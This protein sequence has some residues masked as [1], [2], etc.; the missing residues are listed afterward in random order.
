MT[1][2]LFQSGTNR[3][4]SL[5]ELQAVFGS[6]L[7][8]LSPDFACLPVGESA[9]PALASRYQA[10]LGGTPKI[11]TPF[12]ALP[13][14]A[15]DDQI[16]NNLCKFFTQTDAHKVWLCLADWRH[17]GVPPLSLTDLKQALTA[18]G[19]SVR[20]SQT[21]RHGAGAA[22]LTHRSRLQEIQ[23]IPAGQR[24]LL[25]RTLTA[26]NIDDWTLRDRAK[27]YAD[28]RK[29]MLPPKLARIMVNLALG[30]QVLADKPAFSLY[31]PFCGT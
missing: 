25:A 7:Q 11:A 22:L 24:L 31:D 5:A 1:E 9:D 26:Q 10:I 23:L 20:F 8:S 21:P 2:L 14:N 19:L 12:D 28:H 18:A 16:I 13:I 30:E 27:P 3:Q 15:T 17:D 4:L 6:R 29:G